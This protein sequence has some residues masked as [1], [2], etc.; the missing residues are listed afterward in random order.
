MGTGSSALPVQGPAERFSFRIGARWARSNTA[1]TRCIPSLATPYPELSVPGERR[2]HL[3]ERRRFLVVS[4]E[5]QHRDALIR[6]LLLVSAPFDST[7]ADVS[8]AGTAADAREVLRFGKLACIFLDNDLPDGSAL[9]LLREMRAEALTAPVIVLVGTRAERAGR[10]AIRAGATDYLLKSELTPPLLGQCLRAAFRHQQSQ[11]QIGKTQ[12]ELRLRDRAIAASSSGIIICG[13]HRPDYPI[14]YCNPAFSAMTG[15]ASGEVIG[16]NCRFLQGEETDARAVQQ[17]RDGLREERNFQVVLRNYRKDG[18]SFWNDLTIS[19]VRDA[20]GALTHFIGVQTDITGR[21][22]AEDALHQAVTRQRAML[23]DVFASVTEGKL[24]L[25]MTPNDLPLSLTRFA[26]AVPLS[27][28]GGIRELRRQSVSA[29]LAVGI[30]DM[31]CHDLEVAVGEAAMNAVVHSATGTGR[32]FL[33]ER[34]TVQVWVEDEGVGIAVADL[35]NA[36]LRRGYS[37][38]GTMGHGFK[39]ILSVVDRVHLLT[40]GAGTTVVVEQD[41]SAPVPGW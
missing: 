37:T 33:H 35:P 10:E 41:R 13:L 28:A 19:P 30:P 20:G 16:R 25:C 38:A 32:V 39:M 12:E 9:D 7:E 31:R 6:A 40:G 5:D 15:Y 17:V 4:D 26:D 21:R 22:E 23:R 18:T 11:E 1:P 14:I 3:T 27:T 2:E 36:T 24:S 34:G 29:C 8:E